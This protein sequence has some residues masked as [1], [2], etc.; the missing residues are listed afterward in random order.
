[1]RRV[2]RKLNSLIEYGDGH[3]IADKFKLCHPVDTDSEED[4]AAFYELIVTTIFDYIQ[5]YG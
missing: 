3:Y 5:H 4:V 2:Y 1:M